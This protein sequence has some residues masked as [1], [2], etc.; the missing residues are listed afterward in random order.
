M[1]MKISQIL[2]IKVDYSNQLPMQNKKNQ[3]YYF[4]QRESLNNSKMLSIPNKILECMFVP[5]KA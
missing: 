2:N 5:F 4:S 1:E 3:A